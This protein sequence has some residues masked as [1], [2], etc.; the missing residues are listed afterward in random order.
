MAQ[1]DAGRFWLIWGCHASI[2]GSTVF[3]GCGEYESTADVLSLDP[4]SM[5]VTWGVLE[6]EL[7]PLVYREPAGP[8]HSAAYGLYVVCVN[9]LLCG[10]VY[11][12][13]CVCVCMREPSALAGR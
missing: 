11:M 5:T 13:V 4:T 3:E 2:N 1:V 10:C 9:V 8:V 6:V 12:Q 7:D